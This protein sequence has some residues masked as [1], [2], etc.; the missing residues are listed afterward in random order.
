VLFGENS[1]TTWDAHGRGL[2]G[3]GEEH[4]AATEDAKE[5]GLESKEGSGAQ[6]RV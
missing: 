5:A 1:G 2:V 6:K 4:T 3:E